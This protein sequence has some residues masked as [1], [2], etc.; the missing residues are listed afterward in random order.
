ML[1]TAAGGWIGLNDRKKEADYIWNFKSTASPSFYTWGDG[2][3][4]NYNKQCNIEN[5]VTMKKFNGKWIDLVCGSFQAYVCE[6]SS[7][8]NGKYLIGG[9]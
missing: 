5:C 7:N 6:V 3:P 4:N 2:E 1:Q 9:A 8:Y